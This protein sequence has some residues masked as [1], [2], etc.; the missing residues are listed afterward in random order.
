MVTTRRLAVVSAERVALAVG[1]ARVRRSEFGIENR[2]PATL[3]IVTEPASDMPQ[4]L[5]GRP[6]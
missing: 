3:V 1:A 6:G 5:V 2:R 4:V